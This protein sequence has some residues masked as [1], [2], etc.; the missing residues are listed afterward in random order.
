M[1]ATTAQ[2]MWGMLFG[3]IGLG[4]FVYG[5]KQKAPVPLAVGVVL[6]VYPLFV[7]NTYL[8][9]LVGVLLCAVP[10]FIRL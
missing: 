1:T 5:R 10:Y 9:V 4:F 8:M 2:L 6:M 7:S 3:S